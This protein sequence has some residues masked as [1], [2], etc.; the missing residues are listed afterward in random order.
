MHR[1]IIAVLVV[2][3]LAVGTQAADAVVQTVRPDTDGAT[4]QWT[5]ETG[6]TDTACSA[7]TCFNALDEA[8]NNPTAGSTGLN[9]EIYE[10]TNTDAQI[11]GFGTTTNVQT[12]RTVDV[13]LYANSDH[14]VNRLNVTLRWSDID[15]LTLTVD[16]PEGG[17]GWVTANF[18]S[19]TLTQAQLDSLEVKVTKT[20]TGAP[21]TKTVFVATLYADI[22]FDPRRD[23]T[24]TLSVS[25][26]PSKDQN[27]AFSDT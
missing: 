11:F 24:E 2:L 7:T 19:L 21:N 18:A 1:L 27:K 25:E 20:S 9:E 22:T 12:V 13:N 23:V 26:S 3:V 14:T 15:Q 17:F 5:L 16:P 6:A 10:S 4:E 8:V